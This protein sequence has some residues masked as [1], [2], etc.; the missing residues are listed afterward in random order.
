[1]DRLIE[2][3]VNGNYL[4]KDSRFAGVQYE[5][6]ARSLHITFDPSWDGY[7]KTVTFWNALNE[8]PVNRLL[9]ADLLDNLVQDTRV[10]TVP[11]PGE[12][13][14][15][16]GEMTF[17][18]DGY[19]VE[20]FVG[21]RA[22]L[23]ASFKIE[24]TDDLT[25]CLS[26]SLVPEEHAAFVG[27]KIL[28]GNE[29]Y[30][31]AAAGYKGDSEHTIFTLDRAFEHP[32]EGA[33]LYPGGGRRQRSVSD[34][35]VVKP[36]PMALAADEPTDPT[37]TQ[38]EQLQTQI[39][40][41][42]GDMQEQ[43]QIAVNAAESASASEDNAKVSETNAAQSA[44]AALQSENYANGFMQDAKFAAEEA[45]DVVKQLNTEYNA[46][47]AKS[48]AVGGTG[49]R[50]GEDTDNAKYYHEQA[51]AD[52]K[53]AEQYK[54]EAKQIAG[55]DWATEAYVDAAVERDIDCGTF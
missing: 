15:V 1:M 19:D 18:I 20:P 32:A 21:G 12:P 36:A 17:V 22:Y 23:T 35:L 24:G 5:A 41:L 44:E 11:I 13:M 27:R 46:L 25:L 50:E 39:D 51:A 43:A 7:A 28:V 48:Y 4:E 42:L 3:K 29:A 34:K 45:Q 40:N 38:A 14:E 9:T 2:I 47:G 16:G 10:Y 33:K 31:I 8:N 6:N 54:N 49:I 26:D 55:G 53:L 30:T 37:P 52:A